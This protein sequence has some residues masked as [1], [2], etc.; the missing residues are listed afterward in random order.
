MEPEGSLS[1]AEERFEKIR[2]RVGL[3]L[4]PA[5]FFLVY[6]LPLLTNHPRAHK[7]AAILALVLVFWMTEAI[8]LPVTALLGTL[9]AVL[10]GIA[11]PKEALAPFADPII[12]LF[13]GSFMLAEAMTIHGL[14]RRFALAA[15]SLAGNRPWCILVVLG[16]ISATI[17]MW[18]SNSATTAMM[19]PLAMGL[20][21]ALNEIHTPRE[22]V[23][24]RF[25]VG[26]LLMIAYGAS[27]GG[28][29][30]PVGTPPNLIGIGLIE[31][32]AGIRIDFVQ[33][34]TLAIPIVV[35]LFVC[36][37]FILFWFHPHTASRLPNTQQ[38]IT[39]MRE[40]LGRLS[41]GEINV[42]IAFLVAVSLWILPGLFAAI[43]GKSAPL[44]RLLAE[45]LDEGMV[46]ILAALLLFVLPI[47]RKGSSMTLT[48]E[49]ATKIDWGTLLLFGGGLSLGKLMFSSGLAD[50]IGHGLVAL[51]GV[52]GLWGMTALGILLAIL[53][54]ETTSNTASANAIIPV[55][56]ALA[57]E[58][59][60]SPLPPALGACLG[61]SFGFM[62]PVSTPPNA[63]VYGSGRVPILAMVRAGIVFDIIGFGLIWGGLRILCPL[64]GWA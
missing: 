3:F 23:R 61:A 2:H 50:A 52:D 21:R 53:V 13:I 56:I 54:S 7:L 28:I 59:G 31:N 9:L 35:A 11:T 45:R 57:K 20:I 8:P 25:S 36:L 58:A 64:L 39:K 30:T 4:G 24:D 19:L 5:L 48:W 51:T 16:A 26:L 41:R 62:L 34:M 1:P 15:L 43:L 17:S 29:G 42:M 60:V 14:H 44:S 27:I 33:W 37:A 22:G 12:F 46:A 18:M 47:K 49:E 32:L 55:M 38:Y 63:I 6:F 40:K 10:F